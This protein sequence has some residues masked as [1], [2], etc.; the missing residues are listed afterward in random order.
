M[1]AIARF[2]LCRLLPVRPPVGR[3]KSWGT[4]RTF[5]RCERDLT[6]NAAGR[7]GRGRAC[8]RALPDRA[9]SR[10]GGAWTGGGRAGII[11]DGVGDR[12]DHQD[13]GDDRRGN[14]PGAPST[15]CR[16]ISVGV[17]VAHVAHRCYSSSTQ[18]AST[19]AVPARLLSAQNRWPASHWNEWPASSE[20][21][22]SE[23]H[24][25]ESNGQWGVTPPFAVNT[26]AACREWKNLL[27]YRCIGPSLAP[28]TPQSPGQLNTGDN[29]YRASAG[30]SGY[31]GG[32]TAPYITKQDGD[33]VP[34]GCYWMM[35]IKLR[36]Q[37]DLLPGSSSGKA[38][39][40]GIAGCLAVLDR[41]RP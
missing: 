36:D 8:S 22:D 18:R 1:F 38:D 34:P 28:G 4:A 15:F 23:R 37:I 3:I 19:A 2:I 25:L 20:S 40:M 14:G 13:H 24:I 29:P 6:W 5:Q 27:L 35:V 17:A 26:F 11:V 30:R 16:T 32:R 33:S 21:S 7:R 31:S 41:S 12:R 39:D 10:A 9:R